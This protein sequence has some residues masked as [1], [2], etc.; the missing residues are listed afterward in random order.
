MSCRLG[1]E[2]SDGDFETADQ[3]P[4]YFGEQFDWEYLF[5]SDMP[6]ELERVANA[7]QIAVYEYWV[8]HGDQLLDLSP[9]G[10]KNFKV[11]DSVVFDEVLEALD[12][13]EVVQDIL[14]TGE[15]QNIFTVKPEARGKLI[16][17]LPKILDRIAKFEEIS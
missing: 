3:T 14:D 6:K 1:F 11:Y 5:S 8:E 13:V 17:E 2:M 16:A 10:P 12:C 15:S 9:L 4:G 7:F